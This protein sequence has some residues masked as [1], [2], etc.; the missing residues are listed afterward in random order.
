MRNAEIFTPPYL[1]SSS[2]PTI[3][4]APDTFGYG[5]TFRID[6]PDA[7][8]I[9][10]VTLLRLGAVTH[11]FNMSQRFNRLSFSPATGGVDVIAPANSNLAPPGH[12][13]LFVLNASG[14]PSVGKIVRVGPSS[15]PTNLAASVVSSSQID[16]AWQDNASSETGF[17]IERCSGA[18]CASFVEIAT[19]GANVTSYQNTGLIAST[20]YS[21]RVRAYNQSGTSAYSNTTSATAT[22]GGGAPAVPS[23]LAA[24]GASSSQIN[25]TWTDSA[26]N[27][28]GF[29][30]ERCSGAGCS[31][32]AEIATVGANVTTYQN[33]GLLAATSYSYRVRAYNQ[34]A[35]SGY[36]NTASATTQDAAPAAPSNLA[37]VPVS[38]S[39][40]SITWTDAA[41][42]ETGFRIER[43]TGTGCTA[44]A[45]IKTVG[46]N[47]TS[48][49]STAC[50][51][52]RVTRSA[53]APKQQREF[54]LLEHRHCDHGEHHAAGGT[55]QSHGRCRLRYPD[56][57]DLDRQR[58]KRERVPDRALQRHRLHVICRDRDGRRQC[59]QL[60]EHRSAPGH[61]LLVPRARL[62]S[63]GNFGYSN[64]ASA[65]YRAGGRRRRAISG[66]CC[67][68]SSQIN[69]AWTDTS[70]NEAGFSIER[71]HGTDCTPR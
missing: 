45:E 17:R 13:L 53:C 10:K 67:A 43:C 39:Q 27:E 51:P 19:V 5:D 26:T 3:T 6:T 18:N 55:D 21:Y 57:P 4:A 15:A 29:R 71:C 56:Q 14:V 47:T 38:N 7:S 8:A 50:S 58:H 33:T 40:I 65:K 32:F 28:S 69:L 16:L 30:I 46:A 25:L 37:A 1:L 63:G 68:S 60:S 61:E 31:S 20:S 9:A 66:R 24:A 52:P 59:D 23:S 49:Q 42:N 44:F 54:R 64:T 22:D 2:R 11:S 62:Q 35:T 70:T 48:Y 12:Y 36:S 41:T 34:S